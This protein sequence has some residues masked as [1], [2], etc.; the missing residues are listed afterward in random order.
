MVLSSYYGNIVPQT[1]QLVAELVDLAVKG[2][3]IRLPEK[4]C[5]CVC[6]CVCV[7]VE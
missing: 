6:V 3:E 7:I 2:L 5:V 4:V 1:P